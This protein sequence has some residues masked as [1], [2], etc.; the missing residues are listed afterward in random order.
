MSLAR[1]VGKVRSA[2]LTGMVWLDRAAAQRFE[3]TAAYGADGAGALRALS[4]SS[5]QIMAAGNDSV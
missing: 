3:T 4:D 5:R 2:G 1:A